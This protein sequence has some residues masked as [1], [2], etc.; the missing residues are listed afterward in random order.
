VLDSRIPPLDK[1]GVAQDVL[2]EVDRAHD[3]GKLPDV[4]RAL[5]GRPDDSAWNALR[6]GLQDQLDR[7]VTNA[8]SR[9]FFLASALTL[10]ALFPLAALRLRRRP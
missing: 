1:L 7:A 6:A 9:P 3:V 5:S 4:G 2:A 8:F 10:C